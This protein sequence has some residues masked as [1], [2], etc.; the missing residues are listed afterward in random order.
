[1]YKS[2]TVDPRETGFKVR[3]PPERFL[4][5]GFLVRNFHSYELVKF[6]CLINVSTPLVGERGTKE[7]EGGE[8]FKKGGSHDCLYGSLPHQPAPLDGSHSGVW[9]PFHPPVSSAFLPQTH[10]LRP[11][12]SGRKNERWGNGPLHDSDPRVPKVTMGSGTSLSTGPVG[13]RCS[14]LF[15]GLSTF[16]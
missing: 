1:M 14:L 12:T 6:Y 5:F 10:R 4:L 15:P 11:G 9:V 7:K 3:A 13:N 16:R 2:S 8:R